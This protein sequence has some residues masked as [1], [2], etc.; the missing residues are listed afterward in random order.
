M[1][2]RNSGFSHK[3]WW[4]FHSFLYVYEIVSGDAQQAGG[5]EVFAKSER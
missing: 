4:N 3:K 5:M 2:Q 1:A